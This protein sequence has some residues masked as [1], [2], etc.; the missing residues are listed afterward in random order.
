[1]ERFAT[2][3]LIVRDWAAEDAEASR[4]RPHAG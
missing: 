3:R 4:L 1:M 2:E